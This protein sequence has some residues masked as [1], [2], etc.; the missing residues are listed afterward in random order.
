MYYNS[1][2]YEKCFYLLAMLDYVSNENK[3]DLCNRYDDIRCMSLKE[4]LYPRGILLLAALDKDDSIKE[5]AKNESIKEFL[6]FNIVENDV[7]NVI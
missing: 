5:K 3:I 2:Q 4:T 1:K 6:N 7:R